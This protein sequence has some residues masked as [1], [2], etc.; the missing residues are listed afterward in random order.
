MQILWLQRTQIFLWPPIICLESLF[1]G[2]WLILCLT[3]KLASWANYATNI[4]NIPTSSLPD[5]SKYW[6]YEV[7]KYSSL[8]FQTLLHLLVAKPRHYVKWLIDIKVSPCSLT[9][10]KVSRDGLFVNHVHS[11]G[12]SQIRHSCSHMQ[13]TSYLFIKVGTFL[14][15]S[16]NPSLSPQSVRLFWSPADPAGVNPGWKMRT[17]VFFSW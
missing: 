9:W 14:S 1:D 6:S 3:A 12:S 4:Q 2:I 16:L 13:H 11:R 17:F 8:A 7:L 10:P 15:A 5:G